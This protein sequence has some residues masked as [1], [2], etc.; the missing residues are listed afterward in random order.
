MS[1]D[2]PKNEIDKNI[3]VYKNKYRLKSFIKLPK[4]KIKIPKYKKLEKVLVFDLDETIGSFHDL[5]LLWNFIEGPKDQKTFDTI[6]DLYPEFL[7]Y[8]I[9]Q[10]LRY[11]INK[12]TTGKCSKLYMYTNNIYSPELPSMISDYLQ[13]KL[14]CET[15]LFDKL[16]LAF[17]VNNNIIE[18]MRTTNKKTYNDLI[19][20]TLIPDTTEICFIDDNYYEKMNNERVYYI[21]PAPYYH[22]LSVDEIIERFSKLNL[23]NNSNL[24]DLY[25]IL[26]YERYINNEKDM[27]KKVFQKIMYYVKDFFY[28]SEDKIK[29]RKI[30]TRIG[31]FTRKK[32]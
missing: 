29:T 2:I 30:K 17:K 13:N 4:S 3:I 9:L 15:T 14:N 27:N 7:R 32:L 25:D 12:K 5:I 10:I 24:N 19:R 23:I 1:H 16:I 31:N 26:K 21:Q 8:G 18:P 22:S 11:I 6:L 20:C 28:L